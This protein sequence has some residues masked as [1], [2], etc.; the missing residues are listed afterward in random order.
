MATSS[1]YGTSQARGLIGSASASLCHSHGNARSEP[2]LRPKPQPV[3]MSDP[4]PTEQ[5]QGSNLH[6]HRHYVGFLTELQWELPHS[7]HS[8]SFNSDQPLVNPSPSIGHF[9][10]CSFQEC[11][12]SAHSLVGT[13]KVLMLLCWLCNA[14]T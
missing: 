8:C 12:F 13:L 2:Q 4:Q 14:L 10:I 7:F 5:S 9:F 11:Q 3:A 1:V 6:P